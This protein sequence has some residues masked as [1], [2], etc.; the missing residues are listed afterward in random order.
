MCYVYAIVYTFR[1]LIKWLM[2]AFI[3]DISSYIRLLEKGRNQQYIIQYKLLET[4]TEEKE[5][6]HRCRKYDNI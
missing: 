4:V 3:S 1:F 6:E 2:Y 5:K